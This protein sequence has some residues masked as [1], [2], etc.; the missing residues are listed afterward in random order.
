MT[1]PY[2]LG[3]AALVLILLGAYWFIA[4]G[5]EPAAPAD[6]SSTAVTSAWIEVV[7]TPV[8]AATSTIKVA[9]RSG[10]EVPAGTTL[11]TGPSGA[12]V[13][14]FPDGSLAHMDSSTTLTLSSISFDES[15][16]SL[17]VK[18]G[19]SIGRVWNKVVGLATPQSTWEVETSNTVATVRGTA[20]GVGFKGG[21]SW[22]LD[23]KHSV[24]V[25]PI[26]PKTKLKI[27]TAEVL[28]KE[29]TMIQLTTADAANASTAIS[30]SSVAAKITPL[31][32]EFRTNAWVR[33]Q[34]ASDVEF[35]AKIKA[36]RA[37]GL[38]DDAVRKELR[39]ADQQLREAVRDARALPTTPVT[40]PAQTNEG[41][42]ATAQTN[43]APAATSPRTTNSPSGSGSVSTTITIT[44]DK[45]LDTLTEGDTVQFKA[46]LAS[47]SD[48]TNT[49]TWSVSGPVG[50]IT[51]N[52]MF[53]A[54]LGENQGEFGE[55]TGAVS[56][57]LP[58]SEVKSFSV[59]V[60]ARVPTG[61][62]T[63]G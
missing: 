47:G 60:K 44:A 40:T 57:T 14:H 56:V 63:E 27:A 24:S 30:S 42:G 35:E 17:V 41:V 33:A 61:L 21:T 36:L 52:G 10:E 59:R 54:L 28:L 45:P 6:T 43:T 34:M 4:K 50:S 39:N 3:G 9:L 37:K 8:Y 25:A 26:D 13:I 5:N 16:N 12:A 29:N 51:Q 7:S 62:G 48:I 58:N 31:I 55:G 2:I 49:L 19:L 18:I 46:T 32:T 11:E 38:S 53:T 23:S 20:F 15:D 22:V 1:K